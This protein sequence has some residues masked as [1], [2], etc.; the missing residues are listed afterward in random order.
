LLN[1][2]SGT[3]IERT[4]DRDASRVYLFKAHLAVRSP[5]F[6]RRQIPM[7]QTQWLV[8]GLA[9][10]AAFG[11]SLALAQDVPADGASQDP[12]SESE[13][14]GQEASAPDP[15]FQPAQVPP[16][17]TAE[18]KW[19]TWSLRVIDRPRTLP[20]GM[21]EA[22]GYFDIVKQVSTVGTV[23][24]STTA[25]GLTAGGGYGV[26]DKLEVRAS[27][28]FSIDPSDAK[29]PLAI[30]AGFGF[31]EGTLAIAGTADFTYDLASKSGGIGVGASVRYKL[32]PELALYTS[33]QLVM[34]LI[35]ESNAS[36]PSDLR[37]PI[38]VAY[39]FSGGLYAFGE[40][41]LASINLVDYIPVLVGGQ[42]ALSPKLEAGAFVTTDLKNSAFDALQMQIFGRAYF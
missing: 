32:M 7:K 12:S 21:I 37:L 31:A 25:L 20:M 5:S 27:Y 38:G 35:A 15:S 22:G 34:T 40:T 10:F 3:T 41:E 13:A 14:T 18:G 4:E 29:G 39:Q 30:G 28:T 42:L 23:T 11:S 2:C 36:K 9:M 16:I 6:Y 8:R 19:A 33:R 24:T 1:H 26:S 17:V